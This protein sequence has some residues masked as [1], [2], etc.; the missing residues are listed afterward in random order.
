MKNR[1]ELAQHLFHGVGIELGVAAGAFSD[2]ILNAQSPDTPSLRV[3]LLYSI[4][5]W[6]DHHDTREY[7]AALLRL[8]G[9]TLRSRLLR[10]TFAEALGLFTDAAFD[11]IYIDGY[12]HTGQD[13]G[14]TLRDW[15]PKLKPGGVFSGHD[16]SALY[17]RTIEEVDA[18]VAAHGLTLHLTT[19]ER[20]P[21]WWVIKP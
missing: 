15:W 17:P 6:T 16:Y 11:F 21:S 13:R 12:A 3:E 20:L 8:E 1:T 19:D 18:F 2:T 5:R 10:M 4:D 9:H 7:V 14:Q